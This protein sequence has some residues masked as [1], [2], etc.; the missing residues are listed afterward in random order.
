MRSFRP[1]HL[2]MAF[3]SIAYI[4]IPVLLYVALILGM[5]LCDRVLFPPPSEKMVN[6]FVL[7][8]FP[9]SVILNTV[10][11]AVRFYVR[12]DCLSAFLCSLV[13]LF[14]ALTLLP[15]VQDFF[16]PGKESHPI[17][18]NESIAVMHFIPFFLF[19]LYYIRVDR[20]KVNDYPQ[21]Y[22]QTI[23]KEKEEA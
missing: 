11:F 18:M 19:N 10:L 12:R 21:V 15:P 2:I 16:Y 3:V 9:G 5:M 7:W 17:M 14:C 1:Y 8:A 13:V 20:K 4:V 23:P 22:H 6:T